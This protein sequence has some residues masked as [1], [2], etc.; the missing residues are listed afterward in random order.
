MHIDIKSSFGLKVR[1]EKIRGDSCLRHRF[2][3]EKMKFSGG[4]MFYRIN[5]VFK[6]V[7]VAEIN[8]EKLIMV[9]RHLGSISE[10]Q[11]ALTIF[12]EPCAIGANTPLPSKLPSLYF[13]PDQPFFKHLKTEC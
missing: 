6:A 5:Y 3:E 13:P 2:S 9:S 12:E 7:N 4:K 10:E 8:D 11:S 1:I